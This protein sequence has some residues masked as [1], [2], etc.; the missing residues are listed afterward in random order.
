MKEL[1]DIPTNFASCEEVVGAI[2]D[3][4]KGK[5][6]CEEDTDEGGPRRSSKKKRRN[7]S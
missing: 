3:S 1:L 6:K 7:K 2:F 5:G 4:S